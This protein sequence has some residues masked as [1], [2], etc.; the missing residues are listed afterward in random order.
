MDTVESV[1][2]N[3]IRSGQE[4]RNPAAFRAA[5][6]R[7]AG[8]GE[9]VANIATTTSLANIRHE[10]KREAGDLW[11]RKMIEEERQEGFE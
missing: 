8:R 2:Q 9:L 6:S 3:A 1:F 4:I 5:L 7:A 11:A 10:K